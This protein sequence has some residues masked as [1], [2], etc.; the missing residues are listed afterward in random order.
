[1]ETERLLQRREDL[2]HATT[3]LKE[4][5]NEEP[6]ELAI[7]GVLHRFEFTFELAWKVMKDKLEFMGVIEK[8]GSPREVIKSAFQYNI[9]DDGEA[10]IEMMLSRNMLSHMYDEKQSRDIYSKIKNTYINLLLKL[11][12]AI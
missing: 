2:V 3:R 8:T 9:I 7:D 11:V 5:L 6:T 10:W 4:A 12:D 1:M